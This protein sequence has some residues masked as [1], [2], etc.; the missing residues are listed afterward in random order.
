MAMKKINLGCNDEISAGAW[1]SLVQSLSPTVEDVNFSGCS[2]QDESA[3][4][5]AEAMVNLPALSTSF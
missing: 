2:L 1:T 5:I 4:V 3:K